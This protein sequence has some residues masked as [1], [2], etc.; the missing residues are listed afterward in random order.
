[1]AVPTMADSAEELEQVTHSRVWSPDVVQ[2]I[3]TLVPLMVFTLL[4]NATPSSVARQR[5]D[6]RGAD[7][8]PTSQRQQPSQRL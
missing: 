2:R 4:G 7:M 6:H 1:M 3:S 5:G 8:R